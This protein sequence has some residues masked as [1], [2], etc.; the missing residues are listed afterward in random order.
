MMK[1]E[2]GQLTRKKKVVRRKR[3]AYFYR[4]GE[5]AGQSGAALPP[6]ALS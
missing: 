1:P 5:H 2:R 4:K 6:T 3:A